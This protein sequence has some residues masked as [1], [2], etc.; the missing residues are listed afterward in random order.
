MNYIK[1]NLLSNDYINGK[2]IHDI[3]NKSDNEIISDEMS[4]IESNFQENYAINNN[5]NIKTETKGK[6]DNR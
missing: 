6:E 2:E 3:K 1:A 5:T 4:N